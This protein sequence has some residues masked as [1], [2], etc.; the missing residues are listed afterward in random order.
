MEDI[1][2]TADDLFESNPKKALA[3]YSQAV[4]EFPEDVRGY[5]G[6][7]RCFYSWNQ[8]DKAVEMQRRRLR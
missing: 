4:E 5:V 1:F 2:Q 3:L 7:A 8:L 6:L